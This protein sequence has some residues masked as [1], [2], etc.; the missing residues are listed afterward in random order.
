MKCIVVDEKIPSLAAILAHLI[1]VCLL[2]SVIVY[3][4][5]FYFIDT[6]NEIKGNGDLNLIMTVIKM[7]ATIKY[8]TCMIKRKMTGVLQAKLLYTYYF[9]FRSHF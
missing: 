6:I 7:F 8:S 3:I 9:Y 1:A 2:L 5:H 4:L